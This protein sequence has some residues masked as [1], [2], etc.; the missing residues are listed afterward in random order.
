MMRFGHF[1]AFLACLVVI[2]HADPFTHRAL[3]QG[4]SAGAESSA[5]A[6]SQDGGM[7]TADSQATST[8]GLTVAEAVSTVEIVENAAVE[9]NKTWIE[10]E[11]NVT[12]DSTCEEVIAA[13]D[14]A[15]DGQVEAVAE[16]Y[17]SAFGT[18][19]VEG[20]GSGC[21]SATA[22]GDA[23]AT[24]YLQIVIDLVVDVNFPDE[25]KEDGAF[26]RAYGNLVNAA[27][28]SAWAEAFADGCAAAKDGEAFVLAEQTSFARAVAAPMITAFAWAKAGA[29]CGEK[30]FAESEIAAMGEL[31]GDVEA[32]TTSTVVTDGDATGD[33]GGA[34]GA[35][36]TEIMED[37]ELFNARIANTKKCRGKFTFCCR[38][39]TD[40]V[41]HCTSS[42]NERLFSCNAEAVEGED[43]VLWVDEELGEE[44]FCDK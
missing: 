26:A 36:V 39:S 10:F 12:D 6:S 17:A 9:I 29:E 13:A 22:S 43:K 32:E 1:A 33:T 2:A 37:E 11:K 3:K 24:A 21:A 5:E 16:V 4:L 15:V 25:D 20:T 35:T 44:C 41:C 8:G 19:T 18:V 14:F 23:T 38:T 31:G 7:A 42:R 34:S 40:D 30:A 27:T 28:A